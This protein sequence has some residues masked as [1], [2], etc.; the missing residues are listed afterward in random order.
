[1]TDRNRDAMRKRLAYEAARLMDEQ[2]IGGYPQAMRKA[3][4][5][6]GV[7][8]RRLWPKKSDV[9]AA[10]LEQRRLFR[11][12]QQAAQLQRVRREALAAM[13][14][15]AH[16]NPRL[17][18]H[19]LWGTANLNSGARLLLFADTPEDVVL[20][21]INRGIPRIQRDRWL[22]YPGGERQSHPAIGFEVEGVSLELVLLPRN[23][24]RNPPL[25]PV[26]EQ[27]EKG[28]STA[29]LR[30]LLEQTSDGDHRLDK[31]T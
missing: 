20:E 3:A 31:E 21:L 11:P 8:D 16:F 17:V 25:D 30:V 24:I 6:L 12:A 23:G 15:L 19:A 7:T 28:M 22:P 1:M 13:E 18:G 9:Q 27:A 14:A 5:R 10:L 4:S 26:T 29:E 2:A